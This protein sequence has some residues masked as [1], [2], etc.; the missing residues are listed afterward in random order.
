MCPVCFDRIKNMVFLC[1]HGTCQM[2]GDQIEGVPFAARPWKNAS[3]SSEA[4]SRFTHSAHSLHSLRSIRIFKGITFLYT[5][6]YTHNIIYITIYR[7]G[8]IKQ[9]YIFNKYS[10]KNIK[11]KYFC[12]APC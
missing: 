7:I 2:C 12:L 9:K 8:L 1:G 4:R 5:Y 11:Q 10:N 3:C 6:I